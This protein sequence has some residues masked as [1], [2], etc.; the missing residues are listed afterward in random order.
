MTREEASQI[1]HQYTKSESLL[2]HARTVELVMRAYAHKLNQ[3][4]E[5]WGNTGLLHDADYE[6]FPDRHPHVVVELLRERGE[7]EMAHAISGHYSHWGVPHNSL[8]DK[9]LLGC[10]EITGFVVA[11]AQVR[12]QRLSGLEAKSVLKKLKQASFA[13][14]VDRG[15]V[16]LGAELLQV[17]LGAHIDFIIQA[18]Q[19]HA[20]EL[21][22]TPVSSEASYQGNFKYQSDS[23]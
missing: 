5:L 18:L 7:E 22:L 11:C 8:L 15:E 16:R 14:S 3:D 21:Q 6:A 4:P 12:P 10:D 1:L 20:E 2:R 9:A 13:A 17:D 23:R 19:P